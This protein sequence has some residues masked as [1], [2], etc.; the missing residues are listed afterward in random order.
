MGSPERYD[1]P[2]DLPIIGRDVAWEV[3]ESVLC[4]VK[5]FTFLATVESGKVKDLSKSLPY[6][7]LLVEC[8][9]VLR[10]DVA[11][12]VL[13]KHDF[14]NLWKLFGGK[15]LSGIWYRVDLEQEGLEVLVA[16]A[17]LK[18]RMFARAVLP[19]LPSLVIGL[20][21]KGALERFEEKPQEEKIIE[22][23]ESIRPIAKWDARPE[24]L[25]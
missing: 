1:V 5:A 17:P 7:F 23:A 14:G 16:Y 15:G 8:P 11:I 24:N 3:I 4:R 9:K 25:K 20:Y 6:A 10:N 21:R 12:P 13:N 2:D 18:R 19:I 22:W